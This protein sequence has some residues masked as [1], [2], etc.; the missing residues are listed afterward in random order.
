METFLEEVGLELIMGGVLD[1]EKM[2]SKRGQGQG[3]VLGGWAA[4]NQN[5]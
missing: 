4:G 2:T 1:R 3:L 5:M